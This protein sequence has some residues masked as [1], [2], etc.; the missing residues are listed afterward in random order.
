MTDTAL[1]QAQFQS[2]ELARQ[3]LEAQ[4]WPNGP[5]CPHCGVIGHGKNVHYKLQGKSNR[6]GLLKCYACREPFTV[7]VGT[8]FERSHVPLNKWLMAVYLLC[9]SKKGMSAHQLHRTIGVSYKTAWFMAHR[10]R[11]AMKPGIINLMGGDGK[12]VEADEA[13]FGTAP[14]QKKRVGGYG[15]K[16]KI[17]SLVERGGIVR[18]MHVATVTSKTLKPMLMNH[19]KPDTHLMTDEAPYYKAAGEYFAEHSKV[20]HSKGEYVRGKVTTNTVEGF[21]SILKRGLIGT[22]HHVSPAH[23]QRY[24]VEFDFRYNNRSKLGVT[25]AERAQI[26]LKGIVGK[27]LTYRRTDDVSEAVQG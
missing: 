18:S 4:V 10:I 1:T 19:V 11:E 7:T 27:R 9:S 12:V 17:V 8:V 23:L 6:P 15:H 24:C 25:D 3:F 26:A 2:P 5:V 16:N 22:Y 21:F 14:G 20:N 13:Y